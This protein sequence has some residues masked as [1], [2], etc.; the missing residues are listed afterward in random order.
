MDDIGKADFYF[1][2]YR[3]N[4]RSLIEMAFKMYQELKTDLRGREAKNQW[5]RNLKLYDRTKNTATKGVQLAPR[6]PLTSVLAKMANEVGDGSANDLPASVDAQIEEA[7][8][9]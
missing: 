3:G 5:E 8:H 1:N 4:Y 2:S 6:G 7:G 9:G